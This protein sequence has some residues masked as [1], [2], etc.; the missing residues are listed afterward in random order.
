MRHV[1]LGAGPA[2][3]VA[4]EHLRQYD[5]GGAITMIGAEPEPPYSRMAIPY[6]LIRQIEE[7]GTH[8][9][10]R[11]GYYE[12]R[13]IEVRRGRA[14]GIDTAA[15]S[16]ELDGGEAVGYDRLLIATGASP[17]TPPIP[18]TDL[19]GVYNCWKLADARAII[20]YC[21]PEKRIVLIGAGFIGC[22]I[23][24]ALAA[25]GAEVHVVEMENRMVPRMM[26]ETAGGMIRQWCEAKGIKVYTS[27]KVES[28]EKSAD[29][30]SV[31]L[32]SGEAVDTDLVITATGVAPNIDFVRDS[33]ID[34]EEGVQVDEF[35]QTSA[36][37]V[38]AAG[39]CAQGRD[40][41]TG[42]YSVQAIQPTAVEHGQI[43]ARSMARG[44]EHRHWGTV[45]MNV[46]ATMGLISSSFGLWMGTDGG[47]SAELLD[48][49][50]FRYLNLQ[51]EDDV[52][53]GAS[54]LGL[55]EHVGVL[56]GLI[57]SKTP[58]RKWKDKLKRDPTRIME[59]YLA[60]T[61]AIGYNAGLFS[62]E[63]P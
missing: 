50:R 23:L 6:Y 57:Q 36:E 52:L 43:A 11:P 56:R 10:K 46:L 21:R 62:P 17:L 13:A 29:G 42:G 5:P 34:V 19:P 55:T 39:D 41:S 35:L 30:L 40:F 58:L 44:H 31:A 4:A 3:V 63:G 33:G 12:Q 51:F 8:L 9:R 32:D 24:E 45:N 27:T 60:N 49:D 54:S 61:H 26:N 53:V 25:S 48:C 28:I 38:Y 16:V 14:T 18:G 22:I 2:G 1:I 20:E 47:E 37:N 59:A 15:G 7:G